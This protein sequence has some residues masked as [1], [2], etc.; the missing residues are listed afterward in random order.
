MKVYEITIQPVTGFGTPLKGDTLFGHLCWQIAY[1]DKV[2]GKGIGD[3]L[4]VYRERPFAVLSSACP[5]FVQDGKRCYAMRTPALP[6]D[7]IFNLPADKKEKIAKRK[8]YKNKVWMV[9]EKGRPLS[10]FKEIQFLDDA[11][12]AAKMND[13]KPNVPYAQMRNKMNRLTGRTGEGFAPFVVNRQVYSPETELVLFAGIDPGLADID[14]IREC[15]ERTGETGFGKDAS[16][17][18]GRF[19]ICGCVEVDLVRMG[20]KTPNA[21]YTLSPCVPGKDMFTNIYFNPFTRFGRHGDILAKSRNPFKNP[22]IMADEGAVMVPK[23]ME[24]TLKRSHIGIALTGLSKAEEGT[25][26]QGYSL[27]IPVNMEA[28]DD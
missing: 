3:L 16:T 24:M 7:W 27:Y 1:D 11:G 28:H 25:V 9:F 5:S 10:S 4:N 8:E 13:R 6:M 15:L 19:R 26:T 12:L 23:D 14:G 21:C 20:S 18:L 22:V 17:G 2:L